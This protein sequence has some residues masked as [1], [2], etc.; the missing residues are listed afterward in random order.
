MKRNNKYEFVFYVNDSCISNVEVI[1]KSLRAAKFKACKIALEDGIDDAKIQ[2]KTLQ[3]CR[4][5]SF[6]RK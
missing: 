6:K 2:K 3:K 4:R 5:E 1:S